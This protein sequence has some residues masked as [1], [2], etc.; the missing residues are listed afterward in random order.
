MSDHWS[1]T[2]HEMG[3]GLAK[4]VR[5][6]ID[7]VDFMDNWQPTKDMSQALQCFNDLRGDDFC[8]FYFACKGDSIDCRVVMKGEPSYNMRA[9]TIPLTLC[10]AILEWKE[11]RTVKNDIL[12]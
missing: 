11:K 10:H 2:E 12:G 9:D 3:L 7:N 4:L 8:E 5:A 1:M 6:D